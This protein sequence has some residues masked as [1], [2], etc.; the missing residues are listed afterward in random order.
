MWKHITLTRVK[1]DCKCLQWNKKDERYHFTVILVLTNREYNS[2]D[3]F[4]K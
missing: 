2:D 3:C 1:K 4:I